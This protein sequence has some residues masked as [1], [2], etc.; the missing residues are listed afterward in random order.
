MKIPKEFA[1]DFE[2]AKL[3]NIFGRITADIE[4]LNEE[5]ELFNLLD[6]KKLHATLKDCVHIED[7]EIV[8]NQPANWDDMVLVIKLLVQFLNEQFDAGTLYLIGKYE[9]EFFEILA[10]L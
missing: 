6:L 1:G 10:K 5:G 7:Q 2:P 3:N 8:F 9:I 4:N